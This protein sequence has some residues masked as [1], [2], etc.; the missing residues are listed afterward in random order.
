MEIIFEIVAWFFWNVV[1]EIVFDVLGALAM[2]AVEAR[3]PD[4]ARHARRLGPRLGMYA[5]VGFAVGLVGVA[6]VPGPAPMPRAARIASLATLPFAGGVAVA[7]A[8]ERR[9]RRLA[10]DGFACGFAFGVGFAAC[11]L[12]FA[13]MR[14]HG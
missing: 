4:L 8:S 1:L 10:R 3:W 5:I 12:A 14:V 6:I 7:A 13:W 2:A 11:R 9:D